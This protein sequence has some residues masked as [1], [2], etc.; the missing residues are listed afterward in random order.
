MRKVPIKRAGRKAF[1]VDGAPVVILGVIAIDIRIKD[2]LFNHY[3]LILRGL[4]HPLLLGFDFLSHY[5]IDILLSGPK[6]LLRLKHP[7]FGFVETEINTN[8]S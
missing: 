2:K 7:K 3:F 1:S 4:I 5:K 6:P 8:I